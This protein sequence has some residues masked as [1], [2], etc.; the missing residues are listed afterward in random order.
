MTNIYLCLNE[1]DIITDV[2]NVDYTIVGD[3]TKIEWDTWDKSYIG[4]WYD[5]SDGIIKENPYPDPVILTKLQFRQKFTLSELTTIYG[6]I[7]TDIVVRIF[8]DD[9]A[10]ASEV[11]MSDQQ[12]LNG[13]GYLYNNGYITYERM[14][15]IIG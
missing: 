12:T 4:Y 13:I 8:L 11:N 6:A 1:M 2:I 14:I 15:E 9:L 7:D 10:V 3:T 5:R